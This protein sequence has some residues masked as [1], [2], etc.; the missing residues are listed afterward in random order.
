MA[1]AQPL[2]DREADRKVEIATAPRMAL[3]Y[4]LS[5]D[6]NPLHADPEIARQAAGEVGA[7]PLRAA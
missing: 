7:A 1:T 2:P 3:L 5:G 6:Y 4:R